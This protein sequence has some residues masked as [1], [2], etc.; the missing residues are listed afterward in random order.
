MRDELRHVFD[1]QV[2][3]GDAF[4]RETLPCVEGER[5]SAVWR[6]KCRTRSLVL[7]AWDKLQG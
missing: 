6:R 1:P 4:L 7:E 3:H 5:D 2:V